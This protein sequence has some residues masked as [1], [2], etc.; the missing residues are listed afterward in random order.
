MTIATEAV[1]REFPTAAAP[2]ARQQAQQLG[3][4]YPLHGC[5]FQ[6]ADASP[7]KEQ[8]RRALGMSV[9]TWLMN[10]VPLRRDD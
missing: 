9:L 8:A 7:A 10:S 6:V 4:A 5:A 2:D 1:T 3:R